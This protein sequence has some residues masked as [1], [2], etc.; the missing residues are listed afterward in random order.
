MEYKP[1]SRAKSKYN[2]E[3]C[4]GAYV[5]VEDEAYICS[6][7]NLHPM[8]TC[9]YGRHRWFT[10]VDHTTR[11]RC[12]YLPDKNGKLI[13]EG[14]IVSD[15]MYKG[16]V[17]WNNNYCRFNLK[18]LSPYEKLDEV[19][20]YDGIEDDG[21]RVNKIIGNIHDNLEILQK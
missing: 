7:E 9:I 19:T 18:I 14:D 6:T 2:N 11:G 5:V 1:E 16:V 21:T 20:L 12:T 3:W 10:E 13:F 8:D 15:G 4:Y 17:V